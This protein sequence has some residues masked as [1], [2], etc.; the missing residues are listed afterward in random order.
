MGTRT[1]TSKIV[2]TVTRIS[3]GAHA[4]QV[5]LALPAVF[6]LALELLLVLVPTR[7]QVRALVMYYCEY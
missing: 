7:A 1:I 2:V 5:I 6:I 3:D 4:L